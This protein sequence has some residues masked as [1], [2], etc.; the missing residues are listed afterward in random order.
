MSTTPRPESANPR[1]PRGMPLRDARDAKRLLA[2][3]VNEVRRGTLDP[4][5]GSCIGYLVNV[6]LAAHAASDFEDR[7]AALESPKG[8]P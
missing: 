6:F 8:K 7:L 3:V 5:R 2:L 4:R 1:T